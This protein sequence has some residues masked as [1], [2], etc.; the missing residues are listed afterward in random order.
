[1]GGANRVDELGKAHGAKNAPHCGKLTAHPEGMGSLLKPTEGTGLRATIFNLSNT[2]M[3]G[4]ILGLPHAIARLGLVAGISLLIATAGLCCITVWML[5]VAMEETRQKSYAEVANV[6]HGPRAGIL[7]DVTIALYNFGTLVSYVMIIGDVVPSFLGFLNAPEALQDRTLVLVLSALVL[8]PLSSMPSMGALRHAS[9]VC[10]LM[11]ACLS[12]ALVLLGTKTIDVSKD[13]YGPVELWSDDLLGFATQLPVL[14]FAYTCNMNV[15]IFY[16]E[17]RAQTYESFDSKFNS[18]REKMMFAMYFSSLLCCVEYLLVA[19]FGYLAFRRHTAPD[20]LTNLHEERFAAAPYVKVGYSLVM[21]TSYPVMCFSCVASLHR[22]FWEFPSMFGDD[23]HAYKRF[24]A[25]SPAVQHDSPLS[26]CVFA[27]PYRWPG[28][29]H[30]KEPAEFVKKDQAGISPP[31]PT[32]WERL[33]LVLALVSSSILLAAVLPDLSVVFGLTGGFCG[34]LVT[35]C[36]PAMFYIRVASKKG[37]RLILG[38][39]AGHLLFIFGLLAG[40]G[41]SAIVALEAINR[42]SSS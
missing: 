28:E 9:L 23:D 29:N 26:P 21:F 4:G 7:V 12:L 38:T 25:C 15:P 31:A 2:I 19:V 41:S 30:L 5:L 36:F 10:I 35:F 8:F 17:L 18:K 27:T 13:S 37:E 40:V 6:L 33:L 39:W 3:G 20:I 22:L 11:I 16:G 32:L 1:M 42:S 14:I 24:E 34:G